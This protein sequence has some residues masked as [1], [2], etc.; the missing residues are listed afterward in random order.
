MG[1]IH[2][3]SN[4]TTIIYSVAAVI[5]SQMII[6]AASTIFDGGK[7]EH[8]LTLIEAAQGDTN[9]RLDTIDKRLDSLRA[10]P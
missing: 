9:K 3:G 5:L 1:N 2:S 8:R 7:L 6:W 4:A 10:N